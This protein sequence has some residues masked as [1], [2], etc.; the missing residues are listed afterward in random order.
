LHAVAGAPLTPAAARMATDLDEAAKELALQVKAA[1]ANKDDEELGRL[2]ETGGLAWETSSVLGCMVADGFLERGKPDE[3]VA[4]LTVLGQRFPR[5]IRPKQLR[6]LALARRGGKDSLREAQAILGV[7]YQK[8][9][10]DPETLGI[11]A[12]TWMDRYTASGDIMDLR[13]SRDMYALAFELA[14]DDSYT[15]VN[16]AAKSVMLGGPEDLEKGRVLAA[17]VQEIVGTT[18]VAGDYWRSATVAEVQLLQ[19]NYE[20]A[21]RLY[22]AAVAGAPAKV[23]NH[24][25]TWKQACR[26]MDALEPDASNRALVRQAFAHLPDCGA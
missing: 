15:G 11:Y 22:S 12:R 20:L 2:F 21:A 14:R 6:A 1:V 7:L 26:L 10:H 19:G 8:G 3:A 17:R 18:A 16:A 5:A 9:E 13:Q 4:V 25:S 23:G 24:A